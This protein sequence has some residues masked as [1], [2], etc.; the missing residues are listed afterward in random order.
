MSL[1]KERAIVIILKHESTS[2]I[3]LPDHIQYLSFPIGSDTSLT[4]TLWSGSMA[5]LISSPVPFPPLFSCLSSF[6]IGLFQAP[7]NHISLGLCPSCFLF[8][9]HSS[10]DILTWLIPSL[11]LNLCSNITFALKS[12]LAIMFKYEHT[13]CPPNL[14]SS[15]YCLH[16]N[17]VHFA[18]LLFFVY[19]DTLECKPMDQDN[20]YF[21]HPILSVRLCSFSGLLKSQYLEW[22]LIHSG[23]LINICWNGWMDGWSNFMKSSLS[24]YYLLFG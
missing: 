16:V 13:P 3:S 18:Y 5:Y 14:F 15:P 19:I 2:V 1:I 20:V 24:K 7:C 8:L 10:L 9:Q 21:Y 11:P 6:L 23:C 4:M 22:Y 12:S 17:T